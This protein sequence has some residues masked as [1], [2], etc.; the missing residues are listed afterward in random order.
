[1]TAVRRQIDELLVRR[2][3][4]GLSPQEEVQLDVLLAR[5]PQIDRDAFERAAATVFLAA[6]AE[7][8]ARMPEGVRARLRGAAASMLKENGSAE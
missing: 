6:C 4:E 2:A 3:T 7:P 1:M 8:S 5:H